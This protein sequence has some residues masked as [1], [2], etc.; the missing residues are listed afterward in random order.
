MNNHFFDTIE[1]ARDFVNQ[2]TRDWEVLETKVAFAIVD[3]LINQEH[4][5]FRD[6]T[7][8]LRYD[9]SIFQYSDQCEVQISWFKYNN[10]VE[11]CKKEDMNAF[12]EEILLSHSE[13]AIILA[14]KY[15][16]YNDNIEMVERF[17]VHKLI[18]D[19]T[20]KE[21]PLRTATIHDSYN[22]FFYLL[23][24]FIK[25]N[26]LLA[27]ILWNNARMI[28]EKINETDNWRKIVLA[29]PYKSHDWVTYL[30]AKKSNETIDFYKKLI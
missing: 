30:L 21:S 29:E 15:A 13:K 2:K 16:I 23:D 28:L 12:N 5:S 10:L 7:N 9:I 3:N 22:C 18:T 1:N 14:F 20:M 26:D 25:S 8:N 27:Q 4:Y 19:Q 17:V 6:T 24:H 11:A